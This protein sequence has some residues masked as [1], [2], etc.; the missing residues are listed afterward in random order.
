MSYDFELEEILASIQKDKERL[1]NLLSQEP[2]KPE[3]DS[4]IVFKALSRRERDAK[5]VITDDI[6]IEIQQEESVEPPQAEENFHLEEIE[7]KEEAVEEAV[8]ETT[9]NSSVSIEESTIDENVVEK[10]VINI[11]PV[12]EDEQ[13]TTDNTIE[14][15]I[16]PIVE[17]VA[18]PVNEPVV[19]IPI[20]EIAETNDTTNLFDEIE[21][22]KPSISD[23][24]D[25]YEEIEELNKEKVNF[26]E[27]FGKLLKAFPQIFV[28][29]QIGIV[30]ISL[31]VAACGAIAGVKIYNYTQVAYL[32]PYIQKYNITYPKG[33][34]EQ[35]C[36]QY[37]KDQSTVGSID[38]DNQNDSFYITN[39]KTANCGFAPKGTD[40][41]K[42]QQF[43]A[44]DVTGMYDIENEY[45]TKEGFLN[46]S[47]KISFS[48]LFEKNE[49][50]V[51]GAYYTNKAPEDDNGYVFPYNIYGNITEKSFN[52]YADSI[53]H[54]S[55]YNTN[56]EMTYDKN[57]ISLYAESDYM[58]RFV[59][60]I[61]CVQVDKSFNKIT[62]A[63]PKEKIH[64][65]QICYDVQGA[66]NPYI[67]S[68]HWYPEIITD[69]ETQKTKKLSADN[70]DFE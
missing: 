52:H 37:G 62:N 48:T 34:L 29:K 26:K 41:Y 45:S 67:F 23:T 56:Y 43:R 33:I 8:E 28:K 58:S 44:I 24:S 70:F 30:A 9:L 32:K 65:P 12:I 15:V 51:I 39:K 64:Y 18:N 50:Q 35:F 42:D 4:D 46:A 6:Q 63:E 69:T 19:D 5:P 11:E 68:G 13:E 27:K 22:P 59:F 16:E 66:K 21:P 36:D 31:V 1:N 57:Y 25:E 53:M 17:P 2:I 38:F 14:T 7:I 20:E 60:V 47:Q 3:S 55:L 10:A 49:Y 40:V 54:R 61:V